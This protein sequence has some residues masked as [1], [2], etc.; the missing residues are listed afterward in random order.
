MK[1]INVAVVVVLV[2]MF[3]LGSL[4][5]AQVATPDTLQGRQ[6]GRAAG[7]RDASFLNVLGGYLFGVLAVG[8]SL[9]A[10]ANI[11]AERILEISSAPEAYRLGFADSYKATKRQRRTLYALIGWVLALSAS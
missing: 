7:A 8:Y 5:L 2:L 3:T 9:I 4:A 6:D 1:R 10:P 11:P